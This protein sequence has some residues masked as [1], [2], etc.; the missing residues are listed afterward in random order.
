MILWQNLVQIHLA[1]YLMLAIVK[2]TAPWL[3]EKWWQHC[4]LRCQQAAADR[5][6][7]GSL[8]CLLP[9]QTCTVFFL[10]LCCGWA[11]LLASMSKVDAMC[12]LTNAAHCAKWQSLVE[13]NVVARETAW[14]HCAQQPGHVA[15]RERIACPIPS[16]VLV[17]L[18]ATEACKVSP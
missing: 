12:C 4:W 8:E 9:R 7:A 6:Y 1:V 14:L 11:S 5:W 2:K 3:R 17:A 15:L 16:P 13:S 18:R 10:I